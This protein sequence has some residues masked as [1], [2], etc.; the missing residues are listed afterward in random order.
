MA[1]SLKINNMK[2]ISHSVSVLVLATFTGA[3][4]AQ[5]G[6]FT[7]AQAAAGRTSYQVNCMSCHLADLRGTNEVR[8]LT[9][10]DFMNTWRERT[11]GQLAAYMQATMPPA[12]AG[13][14][15]LGAET[16]VNL[17][18]FLLAANGAS[19][20]TSALTATSTVQIGAVASGEFPQTL[21]EQ[22]VAAGPGLSPAHP[23]R[24]R[25]RRESRLRVKCRAIGP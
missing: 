15:G 20:G 22:L 23:P 9:G 3:A 16:Y 17:V 21:R 4:G 12:P 6:A 18:A 11:A 24:K 19:P 7:A 1:C 5:E 13:P 8:P 2:R 25:A 10:G 14:G